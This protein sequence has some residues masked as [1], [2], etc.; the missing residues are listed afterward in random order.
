MKTLFLIIDLWKIVS[1]GYSIIKVG[2]MD[3]NEENNYKD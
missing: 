3:F 1:G 2:L